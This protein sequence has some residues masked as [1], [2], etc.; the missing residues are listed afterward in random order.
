MA[1]PKKRKPKKHPKHMTTEEA[2]KHI[3][4]PHIVKRLKRHVEESHVQKPTKA[5]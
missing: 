4:H 3:F 2:V 5:E 1:A